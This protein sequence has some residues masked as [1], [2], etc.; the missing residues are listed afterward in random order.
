M[1]I[2]Y[3]G[4]MRF[5]VQA[6]AHTIVIDQPVRGGG[7]DAGPSPTELLAASAGSCVGTFILYYLRKRDLDGTGLR[8]EVNY[9]YAEHP[10]R[11]DRIETRVFLP[12]QI[13]DEH[14]PGL[15]KF[16]QECTVHNTLHGMPEV[17]IAFVRD[18]P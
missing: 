7:E 10:R 15:S 8:I 18:E 2:T 12:P 3:D 11:M 6:G 16:A 4:G 1:L 9:T 17:P 13:D 5:T 14:L